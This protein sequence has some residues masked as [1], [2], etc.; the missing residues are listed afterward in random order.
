MVQ[1]NNS[2]FQPIYSLV[3]SIKLI[4]LHQHPMAI[5]RDYQFKRY[6]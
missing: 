1:P 2:T 5:H 6:D 4:N 3:D